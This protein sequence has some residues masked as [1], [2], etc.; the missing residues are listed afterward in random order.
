MENSDNETLVEEEQLAIKKLEQIWG[1]T[2][3]R[4]WNYD[5]NNGHVTS[6]HVT[7]INGSSIFSVSLVPSTRGENVKK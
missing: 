2:L 6:I 5:A 4:P 1:R 3:T 7:D